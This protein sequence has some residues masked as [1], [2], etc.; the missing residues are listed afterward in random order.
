MG[1]DP[2]AELRA[3]KHGVYATKT[4]TPERRSMRAELAE[5]LDTRA[6][7]IDAL[8]GAAIDTYTLAQVAQAYV[9][10]KQAEGAE[11]DN[12]A[13]LGRLPA[14][15]NSAG[16]AL[17]ALL[18]AMPKDAENVLDITDLLKGGNHGED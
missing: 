18:D 2:K 4:M 13:L 7:V 3:L 1:K 11:L 16:R 15:W 10:Q 14:F 6:G 5:Q 8:K 17:K 12:I 9:I